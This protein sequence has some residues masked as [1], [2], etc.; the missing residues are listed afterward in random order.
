MRKTMLLEEGDVKS[1]G[2]D[3]RQFFFI[4]MCTEQRAD[5]VYDSMS[6]DGNL[7]MDLQG[8]HML[9]KQMGR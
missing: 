2:N 5:E 3:S 1:V 7:G 4:R 9:S 8:K 6:G